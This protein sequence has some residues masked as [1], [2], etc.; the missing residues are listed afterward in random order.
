MDNV[1]GPN[2]SPNETVNIAPGE[3]RIPVSFTL[4][5][6]WEALAFS[7]TIPQEETTLTRNKKSQ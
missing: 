2:I 1:D 5:P 3:G 6:N 4:K 7:K